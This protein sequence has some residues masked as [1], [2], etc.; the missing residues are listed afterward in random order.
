MFMSPDHDDDD[1]DGAALLCVLWLFSVLY[2]FRCTVFMY[3]ER[4][5]REKIMYFLG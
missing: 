1:A 3:T 5:G 2:H 4:G